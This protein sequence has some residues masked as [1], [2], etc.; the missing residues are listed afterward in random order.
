MT[1]FSLDDWVSIPGRGKYEEESKSNLNMAI[2]IQNHV[3][4]GC[5][6]EEFFLA[7]SRH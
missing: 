5:T 3:V 6:T 7:E 1:G 2:K 4:D